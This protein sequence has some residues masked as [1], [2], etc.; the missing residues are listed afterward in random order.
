MGF[1]SGV[2]DRNPVM[3]TDVDKLVHICIYLYGPV[4]VQVQLRTHIIGCRSG[5][6]IGGLLILAETA[7]QDGA[8]KRSKLCHFSDFSESLGQN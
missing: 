1:F 4:Q 8:A 5:Y 7:N 6:S 3:W 2:H